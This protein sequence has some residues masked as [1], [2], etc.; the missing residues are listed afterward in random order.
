[1]ATSQIDIEPGNNE[2]MDFKPIRL[3]DIELSLP[4]QEIT[5]VDREAGRVYRRGLAFIYLHHYPLGMIELEFDGQSLPAGRLAGMIWTAL[6]E[7]INQHLR[8]DGLAAISYLDANGLPT[9]AQPACWQSIDNALSTPRSASVVICTRDHPD[10]LSVC[11]DSLCYLDYPNY[12]I[13]LVDNAPATNATY[14]LFEKR[15]KQMKNLQYVREDRPGL[16]AARNC[17]LAKAEGEI[18]AFTDDDVIVDSQW[19]KRLVQGFASCKDT[20]CVTGLVLPAEIE[21]PAQAMMEQFGGMGKGF[22]QRS[23]DLQYHR[24]RHPLFPFTAG[25]FGVGANMAYRTSVLRRFGGF[26]PALGTGTDACGG[27]D[28]AMFFK[29]ITHGYR[30]VYQPGAFIHHYHRR[31]YAAFQKQAYF[32]G[33]GLTA[34][35]TKILLDRPSLLIN[36][37]LRVPAGLWYLFSHNSPKNQKKLANYPAEINQLERKGMLYGPLA[38]WRSRRQAK[39]Y[40]WQHALAQNSAADLPAQ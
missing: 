22:S 10:S 25:T 39:A 6:S 2:M 13:I 11:L 37:A 21:T 28:L 5:P 34:Y 23:F 29:V 38:Y 35:L 30:L 24:S 27:E 17:G 7:P 31:T 12:E 9:S 3:L 33:V 1:M 40:E 16:S 20:A 8:K 4:L 19:L 32:Y 36:V 14:A 18:I 26:D 15:S